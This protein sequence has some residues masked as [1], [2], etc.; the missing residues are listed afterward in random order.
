MTKQVMPQGIQDRMFN[1]M[2]KDS[3]CYFLS[4][5]EWA[6][7]DNAT[8]EL[9]SEES[10]T[11]V[12][13]NLYEFCV[14]QGFMQRDCFILKPWEVYNT[15]YGEKKYKDVR[16]EPADRAQPVSRSYIIRWER[17]MYGHFTLCYKG[18]PWDPMNPD[19]PA[20]KLYKAVS[21]RVLL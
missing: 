12:I 16:I 6:W 18:E 19:R 8:C 15:A 10:M 7:R 11:G 20:A 9:K 3:G 17:P 2:I 13:E 1:P 5:V 4:L 14:A 21:L